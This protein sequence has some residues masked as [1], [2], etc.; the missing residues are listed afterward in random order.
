[1]KKYF[2][3][4]LAFFF[5][6]PASSA[7]PALM[8]SEI[9]ITGGTG[10]ANDDFIELYNPNSVPVD[11]SGYRL[12]YKNSGGTENSLNKIGSGTCIAAHGYYL[13]ANNKGV[14]LS[15]ADTDTGTGLSPKYSLALKPPENIGDTILDSVSWE[16]DHPFD[17]S[18]FKFSSSPE[19]NESMVRNI[20]TGDWLPDFSPTP[21]PTKSTD[22]SCP[23]PET[24]TDE[25]T[26]STSPSTTSSTIRLNEVFPNPSAKGDAGE[27]I[28]LYNF[29]TEPADISGW[30]ILDA[31]AL[32]KKSEGASLTKIVF[33]DKYVVEP[34]KY[35]VIPDDE[36]R[37]SITL[38]NTNEAFS[39]FDKNGVLIDSMSFDKS[40]ENISLNYAASGWRGGTPTPGA[41]NQINNLPETKEKVP[42]KGFKGIPVSFS[43]KG[44]DAD[45][46][47][48]KHT[49]DF[50]DGHKS[51]KAETS[52]AYEEKGTYIVTLTTT[53]GVED[54]VETFPIEIRSY[55]P[56]E[57]R[58]TS[59]VP[60]PSG[61]DSDNEW[62]MLEN[63]EKKEV[64]LKGF[65]IATGWKSLANH[66]VREDF[67]IAPKSE[68][69]LTRTHSLFTLPNQKGRVELRAP[70]GKALQKIK[71]KL[72]TSVGEEIVYRKEKGRRWEWIEDE[73]RIRN[74]ESWENA[75]E[76]IP[77]TTVPEEIQTPEEDIAPEAMTLEETEK[78]T[79]EQPEKIPAGLL[80]EN[81]DRP[82][83]TTLLSYGT[84][85]RLPENIAY[86]PAD[87]P[88]NISPEKT[89]SP[90]V[91]ESDDFLAD[92]NASI[93]GLLNRPQE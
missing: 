85:I 79:E 71:Y 9:Q 32:K 57:V 1:M 80:S 70:N 65:G 76:T 50:G 11:I 41:A 54:T 88:E 66:P 58:I 30:E 33:P 39:L 92:L 8:L 25:T 21:T 59:L 5:P 44:K 6:S 52:H 38:N 2:F 3:F 60:N 55:E 19:A 83:P 86:A 35:L 13:W 45:R 69:K 15:I 64:N 42:K 68:A 4:F 53:D 67:I 75:A 89:G 61:K 73:S 90:D 26:D 18:A 40:K 87:A 27:F 12:R 23:A 43:A 10:H 82:K 36:I 51:Y 81:T 22:T 47:K 91:P 16:S 63:R 74:Q 48:L 17:E 29:G 62:V 20:A 14:F 7:S 77:E 49:W 31:L 46:Q 28:E 24:T 93:N 34:Q 56:P 84:R 78:E 72:D 37:L